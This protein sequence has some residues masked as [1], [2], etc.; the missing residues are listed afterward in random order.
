[1]SLYSNFEL[2][3]LNQNRRFQKDRS[4][5]PPVQ[6][7]QTLMWVWHRKKPI[8]YIP[9][10]YKTDSIFLPA[11]TFLSAK[12]SKHKY[13]LTGSDV[14]ANIDATPTGASATI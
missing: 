11:R 9:K 4:P 8:P 6:A 13:V 5:P 12:E 1:M 2:G 7:L 3:R 10:S 14:L